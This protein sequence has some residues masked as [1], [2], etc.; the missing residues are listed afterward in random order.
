[1]SSA[2]GANSNTTRVTSFYVKPGLVTLYGIGAD[3]FV[4][5]GVV[6]I[7]FTPPWAL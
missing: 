4:G 2:S 3:F 5:A 7:F 6:M 1:M